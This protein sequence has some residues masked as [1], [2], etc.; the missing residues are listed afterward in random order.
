MRIVL[1]ACLCLAACR[2][3][4][5]KLYTLVPTDPSASAT[6]LT[7]ATIIE[8]RRV[9]IPAYLDRPE[10]VRGGADYRVRVSGNERWSEPFGDLIQRV[11]TADL[12]RRVPTAT[13]YSDTGAIAATATSVVEVDLSRLDADDRDHAILEATVA[14]RDPD[15]A[16]QTRFR[17]VRFDVPIDGPGAPAYAAALSAAAGQLADVIIAAI[18]APPPRS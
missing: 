5:P 3:P 1:L 11:L 18:A 15:S 10:M 14:I 7:G 16:E 8:L 12:A 13:V 17:H 4:D 2:S 6:Q 9:N